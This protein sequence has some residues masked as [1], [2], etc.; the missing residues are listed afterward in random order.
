MKRLRSSHKSVCHGSFLLVR[1][2][3]TMLQGDLFA[4]LVESRLQQVGR[5]L[6]IEIVN[7][8]FEELA[9]KES[10]FHGPCLGLRQKSLSRGDF[11]HTHC[12]LIS[13]QADGNIQ[14]MF[15]SPY[16]Q[17][18]RRISP[19]QAEGRFEQTLGD[20][21]SA[22]EQ[23][24]HDAEHY[25]A[26]FVT[27]AQKMGKKRQLRKARSLV[28]G[29]V[30]IEAV[31]ALSILT[32]V[33]LCLLKLSLNVLY[34]RQWILQ[35]TVT[36]AYMTYERAY[37]ERIP[38]EDLLASNSPWPVFPATTSTVLELGKLPGGKSITGTIVRTRMADSGNYPIDG[39]T[40]TLATNPAGM[41][42]WKAQS[43]VTYKVGK[44]TYA[45]SRTVLRSQ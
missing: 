19:A 36:D 18:F 3:R 24:A 38:F 2:Q 12:G 25:P 15:G 22:E 16:N 30:M 31:M 27:H 32:V 14:R 13:G 37:A 29:F 21:R 23:N 4:Q 39:G 7:R 10:T 35:Q 42:V 6:R 9:A 17:L 26:K 8:E 11:N 44:R 20:G 41:K 1:Q 33:G 40:G 5:C 43:V 28:R 45:K 34:P